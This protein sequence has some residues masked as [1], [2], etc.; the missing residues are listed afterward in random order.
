MK[1]N[2]TLLILNLSN[3]DNEMYA[4]IGYFNIMFYRFIDNTHEVQISNNNINSL[5]D[6]LNLNNVP[7]LH[8]KHSEGIDKEFG[9]YVQ[10]FVESNAFMLPNNHIELKVKSIITKK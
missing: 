6:F 10:I 1:K 9:T 3:L 5:L 7:Y 8:T 2:E 4:N